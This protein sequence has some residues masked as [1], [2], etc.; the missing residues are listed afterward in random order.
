LSFENEVT[1]EKATQSGNLDEVHSKFEKAYE[2]LL[3]IAGRSYLNIIGGKVRKAARE[4]DDECPADTSLIVGRF[5]KGMRDD[6]SDAVK[7]G[8]K[9]FP[10]WSRM[11]YK[12]RLKIIKKAAGLM[13]KD[14]FLL[15]A[16]VTIDN[17]KNRYEAMADVD[18]AIDFIDYYHWQMEKNDGFTREM[19]S[20][21]SEEKAKSVLRPYGVWAVI[22]PFN[23][24]AAI[25]TGMTTGAL[26]TGNTVVL[27]P[28]SPVPLPVY[29]VYDIFSRAGLPDGVLN[30]VAGPGGEVG[31]ALINHRE[32]GGVVFT[33]SKEIG[34]GIIRQTG[35][36]H[37]I[38]VIAEMGGKNPIIVTSEANVDDAVAGVANSAFGYGG[39]KCS[40]C[41][42]VYVHS[43][44]YGEFTSKLVDRTKRLKIGD[45]AQRDVFLGPVVTD[46]VVKDFERCADMARKDG[47]VIAGGLRLTDGA[48]GKGH[49][50]QPTIAADLPPDHYLIRNEL[51]LPFLCLQ[52]VASLEEAMKE[53][54]DVEFGL[55]AGIFSQDEKELEYFF[56]NI[57]AGVTYSNRKRG[58]STGAMVGGQSFG[59][60]KASGSTGKGAGGEYYLLQ[61]M[62]E[63]SR[64]VCKR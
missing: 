4:F 36:H 18:E 12:E 16:A 1:F 60:W 31:D 43:S 59:G 9:A 38:P 39:Q 29:M 58:G 24:P 7:A 55:T 2:S 51:F 62:R 25:T 54:N 6:V 35:R 46:K 56:D 45:P 49:F 20:P 13:R 8:G 27:K 64:T 21:F 11:D 52:N 61:F 40:A 15:A 50:L 53:A 5:Q 34:Y 42:R 3:E 47:R 44:V 37:P 17:G 57:E 26:I 22:C 32:V 23:F 41:S 14:K 63:Q 28:S 48:F 19:Y 30:F 10:D 33:G